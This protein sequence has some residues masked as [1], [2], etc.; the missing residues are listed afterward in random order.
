MEEANF[1]L[2]KHRIL[3]ID[4][5][6]D[7]ALSLK[8]LLIL[9]GA[10]VDVA[11]NGNEGIFQHIQLPYDLIITDIVMPVMDGLEVV[12]WVKENSPNTKILVISGGGYF[13]FRDY[14]VMAKNLGADFVFQKPICYDEVIAAVK[15]CI[16]DKSQ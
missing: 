10:L 13:D 9:E 2:K 12:M 11:Y 16:S 6:V 14:L 4:D 8:E 1:N 5:D 7:L 15:K 3:V